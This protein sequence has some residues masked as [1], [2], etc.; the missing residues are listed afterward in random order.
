MEILKK[1]HLVLDNTLMVTGFVEVGEGILVGTQCNLGG[2]FRNM[3][4]PSRQNER[5]QSISGKGRGN[6]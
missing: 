6:S 4:G 5:V 2:T 3:E 1:G